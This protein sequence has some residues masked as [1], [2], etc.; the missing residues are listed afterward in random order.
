MSE[1]E[2]PVEQTA[3]KRVDHTGAAYWLTAERLEEVHQR[4]DQQEEVRE[5]GQRLVAGKHRTEQM[6]AGLAHRVESAFGLEAA[7]FVVE[8]RTSDEWHPY[9]MYHRRRM[10]LADVAI[11]VDIGIEV[12][13]DT[14]VEAAH[15]IAVE[16]AHDTAVEAAHDTEVAAGRDIG[17][18]AGRD[19][20]AG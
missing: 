19:V 14:G 8:V 17:F 3:H 5:Q 4:R 7:P 12:D 1:E 15:D 11:V 20:W 16:A 6:A 2:V 9:Q 13:V 10:N 18:E